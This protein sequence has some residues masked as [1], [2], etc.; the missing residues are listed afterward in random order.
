MTS[1][2]GSVTI[3]MLGLIM[4]VLAIGGLVLDLW[5]VLDEKHRVEAIADAAAAAGSAMI[6]ETHYRATGQV[7]LDQPQA[8]SRAAEIIG[9]TGPVEASVIQT[10]PTRVTVTLTQGVDLSLLQ[11]LLP[12]E[13]RIIVR[14]QASGSPRLYP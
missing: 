3:W 2:R 10:D 11:L 4:V 12:G 8:R 13:D 5:R 9:A 14:A 1:E 6:D 7:I